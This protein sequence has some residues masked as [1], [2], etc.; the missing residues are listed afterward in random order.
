[1]EFGE[2]QQ[3]DKRQKSANAEAVA[4][5]Q[6]GGLASLMQYGSDDDNDGAEITGP[7]GMAGT[8][9]CRSLLKNSMSMLPATIQIASSTLQ[10]QSVISGSYNQF[11][12]KR[13][14]EHMPPVM[15]ST[16]VAALLSAASPI[17]YTPIL[18]Y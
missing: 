11:G 10:N 9:T 7:N 2:G 17:R 14:L 6:I 18:A 12:F 3:A 4:D 5:G 16:Q 13:V 8:Y 1:M 15:H